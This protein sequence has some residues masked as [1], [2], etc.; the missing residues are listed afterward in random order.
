MQQRHTVPAFL[1]AVSKKFGDDNAGNLTVQITYSMFVTVFPL[2]LLL[3]TILS[4]VLA[5]DPAGRARVLHSAVGQFPILGTQLAHNIHAMRRSSVFGLVFGVLGLVYG[6]TGLA[7][8]GLYSMEQIWNIPSALRPNFLTRLIRSLIFL[9][10]LAV[11]LIVTT[12]LAGFGTFGQHNYVLGMVGEVIALFVNVGIYFAAFRV[13]TPKQVKT[14]SLVPG[15]VVGGVA[16]TILQA[17][18]GYIVGHDL[19][20]ASALYGM[21]GLVL[22]LVAWIYLGA[23]VTLYSAELNTVLHHHLWPRGMVQPPLTEAD[24]RSLAFQVTQNQRRPEQEVETRFRARPM[25]QDEYRLRGYKVDNT[26]P[27]I[28]RKSHNDNESTLVSDGTETEPERVVGS[29]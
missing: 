18:G 26:V 28:E 17:V 6:S 11:G 10:V 1:F 7:Q 5:N 29:D 21:F 22:G 25:S 16:W 9:V 8:A 12:G 13:L 27:G 19:K 4:I 24:Q 2:L 23:E 15:V 20:G 3:V 14:R